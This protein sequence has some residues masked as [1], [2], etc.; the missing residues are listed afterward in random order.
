MVSSG[1]S[2][3]N[4]RSKVTKEDRDKADKAWSDLGA[5][6]DK[7]W[8]AWWVVVFV[9]LLL[10][11]VWWA[12]K[13][14]A[15]KKEQIRTDFL[16]VPPIVYFHG[17]AGKNHHRMNGVFHLL[18]GLQNKRPVWTKR[19][20]GSNHTES[21]LLYD[22]CG[23]WLLS[24]D[25]E[26][27]GK[28]C[29]GW[30][31][32]RDCRVPWDC[33]G[34]WSV[35]G[36]KRR[37]WVKLG[38][39]FMA[40]PVWDE[41][42]IPLGH[43]GE[44][45]S[46]Q[47]ETLLQQFHGI[48]IVIPW[49]NGSDPEWLE[50][51]AATCAEWNRLFAW[52]DALRRGTWAKKCLKEK[53]KERSGGWWGAEPACVA[54]DTC[55]TD[56]N[57]QCLEEFT[58]E[59]CGSRVK[60]ISDHDEL[61]YLL[62]SLEKNL[63][64]HTGRI[65]LVGPQG[66]RPKWLREVSG[67]SGR[68]SIFTQ[69]ELL[70]SAMASEYYISHATRGGAGGFAPGSLFNDFPV[71]NGLSFLPNVSRYVL[72][73]DDDLVLA[74]PLKLCGLFTLPPEAGV[75]FFADVYES[76][77]ITDPYHGIFRSLIEYSAR[78]WLDS[79]PAHQ[80]AVAKEEARVYYDP[81]HAPKLLDMQVFE[82]LWRQFPTELSD[83]LDTPFRYPNTTDIIGL[84]HS[85]LARRN[86][87]VLHRS[88][89]AIVSCNYTCTSNVSLPG[90]PWLLDLQEFPDGVLAPH[91]QWF[92]EVYFKNGTIEEWL[93]EMEDMLQPTED[94]LP[95]IVSF[96]DQLHTEGGAS[97]EVDCMREKWLLQLLPEPSIYEDPTFPP[98]NCRAIQQAESEA[99]EEEGQVVRDEL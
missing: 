38:G 82:D 43:T 40:T 12:K 29:D 91:L 80:G 78:L 97:P 70:E 10:G 64:W 3:K 63:P 81:Y 4:Y 75:K 69:E 84:H 60:S 62:R 47:E 39:S 94:V 49:I 32:A 41:S 48:D 33:Q 85:E 18:E 7:A 23:S 22:R 73:L 77:K 30:A 28:S 37:G 71:Q 58:E 45:S 55:K 2:V 68:L 27:A 50:R 13:V 34:L 17:W 21:Y 72:L 52:P 46:D 53:A 11:M 74:R 59:H 66:Q 88:H 61:R 65:F 20:P 15:Y 92:F 8:G 26:G 6:S 57:T 19:A 1:Q 16:H 79:K 51:R 83:S 95:Q 35:Y 25:A 90:K 56:P 99:T 44:C 96:Q 31:Y 87:E 54:D 36:G 42:L 76:R 14:V 98:V 5:E 89:A 24:H 86:H 67:A 93:Y 9:A